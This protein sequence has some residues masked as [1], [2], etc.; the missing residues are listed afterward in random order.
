MDADAE[1]AT[2]AQLMTL[3]PMF[4]EV[5]AFMRHVSEEERSDRSEPLID[6]TLAARFVDAAAPPRTEG[7]ARGSSAALNHHARV[8]GGGDARWG[9][10]PCSNAGHQQ[11]MQL[12]PLFEETKQYLR[13]TET[14]DRSAPLLLPSATGQARRQLMQL[15][16]LFEETK[17]Y[18]RP[19]ET[20]DRSSPLLLLLPGDEP[21]SPPPPSAPPQRVADNQLVDALFPELGSALAALER[22][23]PADVR[24]YLG[25]E[26]LGCRGGDAGARWPA[27]TPPPLPSAAAAAARR[28]RQQQ[29]VISFFD[30]EVAPALRQALRQV[31]SGSSSARRSAGG[32]GETAAVRQLGH[33]LLRMSEQQR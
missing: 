14:A 10:G 7:T 3:V 31:H 11:L 16:P 6:P 27:R 26:L 23:R 22:E 30:A 12:V 17:Q 33:A 29:S 18:L 1:V 15:V 19:T 2:H 25:D 5:K 8:E 21:P 4:G 32:G 28:R 24:R 20:A 13:P 9:G